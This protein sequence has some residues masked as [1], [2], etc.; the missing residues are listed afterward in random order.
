MPISREEGKATGKQPY[1]IA[2]FE[3]TVPK[4]ASLVTACVRGFAE[5]SPASGAE[6]PDMQT[7]THTQSGRGDVEVVSKILNAF[8]SA[9]R[10]VSS[11]PK[12]K[13]K[14]AL[15][16]KLEGVLLARSIKPLSTLLSPVLS[17]SKGKATSATSATARAKAKANTGP[18][19]DVTVKTPATTTATAPSI[20]GSTGPSTEGQKTAWVSEPQPGTLSK[21][22]RRGPV[23][24]TTT[25][26]PTMNMKI[27][28][29]G[30]ESASVRQT[31]T[32]APSLPQTASPSGKGGTGML[33]ASSAVSETSPYASGGFP[34][35]FRS[36]H[37]PAVPTTA[38]GS[39]TPSERTPPSLDRREKGKEGKP[40][41]SPIARRD[42]A[43]ASSSTSKRW[44]FV[45]PIFEDET[46]MMRPMGTT[47]LRTSCHSQVMTLK[48]ALRP[49][50][51]SSSSSASKSKKQKQE[52]G[53]GGEGEEAYS[54]SD[55]LGPSQISSRLKFPVGVLVSFQLKRPFE[56]R[57]TFSSPNLSGDFWTAASGNAIA[58]AREAIKAEKQ[59]GQLLMHQILWMSLMLPESKKLFRDFHLAQ[60]ESARPQC[61]LDLEAGLFTVM[62]CH[63]VIEETYLSK[64]PSALDLAVARD[65]ASQRCL[66]IARRWNEIG[67]G[68]QMRFDTL[69]ENMSEVWQR[70]EKEG[71]SVE[72]DTTTLFARQGP[73]ALLEVPLKTV[74][75]VDVRFAHVLRDDHFPGSRVSAGSPVEKPKEEEGAEKGK[76]ALPFQPPVDAS[77]SA[78][79]SAPE[80]EPS[81]SVQQQ[82]KQKPADY[83]TP[84]LIPMDAIENRTSTSSSSSSAA[85]PPAPKE[86]RRGI[87]GP[88]T[89]L[90][91]KGNEG[92][93]E[94]D[95]KKG[96]ERE[97]ASKKGQEAEGG[98]AAPINSKKTQT[99]SSSSTKP[100]T[101]AAPGDTSTS[102]SISAGSTNISLALS[103]ASLQK[104][105][106]DTKEKEGIPPLALPRPTA[107]SRG[108]GFLTSGPNEQQT[109]RGKEA[110]THTSPS[111]SLDYTPPTQPKLDSASTT[112]KR[113]P[114]S[115]SPSPS[116]SAAAEKGRQL[117]TPARSPSPS[118]SSDTI[119]TSNVALSAYMEK[120]KRMTEIAPPKK[121]PSPTF[122]PQQATHAGS[123]SLS[124]PLEKPGETAARI[125]AAAVASREGGK[126]KSEES[127]LVA[128][129]Q[130][131][132]EKF[133]LSVQSETAHT[134]LPDE[135]AKETLE[136]KGVTDK[137][138]EKGKGGDRVQV[139]VGMKGEISE[140]ADLA[141]GGERGRVQRPT[142]PPLVT[143]KRHTTPTYPT[144]VLG[145]A[146][147]LPITDQ[148]AE[149]VQYPPKEKE[150]EGVSVGAT[151]ATEGS[152]Y[153]SMRELL[154]KFGK[155]LSPPQPDSTAWGQ[156][157][158]PPQDDV[159]D[160]DSGGSVPDGER[161]GHVQSLEEGRE[162]E[163]GGSGS[164]AWQGLFDW[165]RKADGDLGG[166]ASPL[167][168]ESGM[169][170]LESVSPFGEG[171]Q[172]PEK[173]EGG[174]SGVSGRG[175]PT[176][177]EMGESA[178]EGGDLFEERE[179]PS[180]C[181]AG[182]SEEDSVAHE[183]SPREREMSYL[184]DPVSGGD[185]GLPPQ[186]RTP[187]P[188]LGSVE[189]E[190]EEPRGFLASPKVPEREG[191][192][193]SV[194]DLTALLA[195]RE[196][197]SP[198]QEEEGR[199]T[200][201]NLT[202]G[203]LASESVL[204]PFREGCLGPIP[205]TSVISEQDDEGVGE[206]VGGSGFP[207]DEGDGEGLPLCGNLED[208]ECH[209]DDE[210]EDVEEWREEVDFGWK[211]MA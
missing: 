163:E 197:R 17:T 162:G 79:S 148:N 198:Q 91:K 2:S 132:K 20:R 62:F 89:R 209:S 53:K 186:L 9:F 5:D 27:S 141:A 129:F 139:G 137:V 63:E 170:G 176:E 143:D 172:T 99:A 15:G 24:N 104:S 205:E 154:A 98:T 32:N 208:W 194:S 57:K 86:S 180:N 45:H 115:P 191:T 182:M 159:I 150:R 26:S 156:Q 31:Q 94:G 126:G 13:E 107:K 101:A 90:A 74:A 82:Q 113:P 3:A 28:P 147:S 111:P 118:Q 69:Y 10:L 88:I 153:A 97:G 41:T 76:T 160:L 165:D 87:T 67:Q 102:L 34:F 72:N 122:S 127:P 110:P 29:A 125:S 128:Y 25:D 18:S 84:V 108:L 55:T 6:K 7:E 184:R 199:R 64:P 120:I 8:S 21:K 168:R 131:L 23:S 50:L 181:A 200:L 173:T 78:S 130:T 112:S 54:L 61:S 114:V 206:D 48:K 71:E 138:V 142:P 51:Q 1:A 109:T 92:E 70:W 121:D 134:S 202:T 19:T 40:V 16:E 195:Q 68:G 188:P 183:I 123:P 175:W 65:A 4:G 140:Q 178:R 81:L 158:H 177:E 37:L 203:L 60:S 46:S 149:G 190:E 96:K 185:K 95:Q 193:L 152:E 192:P 11:S 22:E 133:G 14:D 12:E 83:P 33:P 201:F 44:E 167:Q 161:G 49:W 56:G 211:R 151:V 117:P 135:R 43:S 80:K 77:P 207:E 164:A 59:K 171:F 100:P 73:C 47:Y 116:L 39:L 179:A 42:T 187:P 169:E 36:S 52:K 155:D 145:S 93:G 58:R 146:S 35:D 157:M 66:A 105:A 189:E 124:F 119:K 38:E 196:A 106:G 136:T 204:P 85:A 103:S 30:G 75:W 166:S 210:E 144:S 174:V